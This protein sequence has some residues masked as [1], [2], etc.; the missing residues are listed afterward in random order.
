MVFVDFRKAFDSVKHPKLWET[1]QRQGFQKI[2]RILKEIYGRAKAYVNMDRR[3]TTFR[4]I[5]GIKQGDL[6]SSSIF[7]SVL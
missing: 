2:V 7:N 6:M 4:E 5:N 3:G 1:L